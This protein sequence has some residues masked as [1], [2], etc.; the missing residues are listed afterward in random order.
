MRFW[1]D[2]ARKLLPPPRS[3]PDRLPCWHSRCQNP[4]RRL[5]TR[6][7]ILA[8]ACAVSF[9]R[10]MSLW[11]DRDRPYGSVRFTKIPSIHVSLEAP[12][13]VSRVYIFVVELARPAMTW[14]ER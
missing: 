14:Q 12:L 2:Y 8:A 7:R 6:E 10:G 13:T 1:G 4:G 9:S 5:E 3:V 11:Y